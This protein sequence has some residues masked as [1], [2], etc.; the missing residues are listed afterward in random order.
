MKIKY[1]KETPTC[2]IPPRYNDSPVWCDLLKV[3]HIY[4]KGRELVVKNG[5]LTS[6][7]LDPWLEEKP[8]CMIYPILYDLCTNKNCSVFQ[9]GQQEWVLEFSIKLPGV[10]RLQRYELGHKLNQVALE[11]CNDLA[12][13]RWTAS[14]KFTVKSVYEQLTKCVNG[15]SFKRIWKPKVPRRLKSLCGLLRQGWGACL[16]SQKNKDKKS[17]YC[18]APS[19]H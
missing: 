3:R 19:L 1:I 18:P 5:K 8:L 17:F 13:W 12:I 6:F 4:L 10:I 11:E 16:S 9:V 14:K 7:W 15:P 2:L